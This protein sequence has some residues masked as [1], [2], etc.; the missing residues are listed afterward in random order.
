[1]R[2]FLLLS[3]A[4]LLAAQPAAAQLMFGAG[5]GDAFS[6]KTSGPAWHA[7]VN[8]PLPPS[9]LLRK[10]EMY[11]TAQQG[12]AAGSPMTCERVRQLY[13]FGRSDRNTMVGAGLAF[14]HERAYF[15]GRLRS[16]SR[17]GAGVYHQRVT[18]TERQGAVPFCVDARNEIVP[19][20]NVPP[21]RDFTVRGAHTGPGVTA[22]AGVRFRVL[23]MDGF[24]DLGAH[25]ARLGG[26]FA[27]GVPFTLG[28]TL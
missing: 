21:A 25:L 4:T 12:S 28:F 15:D 27:G 26:D 9:R 20:Q 5:Y 17:G 19:C 3:M 11:A 22:S 16:Y 23:G 14:R 24:V 13:C 6:G 8:V 18:S 1:M 2:A 7:R 10:A